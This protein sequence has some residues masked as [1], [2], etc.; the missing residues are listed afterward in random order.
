MS[1]QSNA[2]GPSTDIEALRK[3]INLPR[4]PVSV[5]W[6]AAARG[7]AAGSEVPGPT[8]TYIMAVLTFTPEDMEELIAEAARHERPRFSA[9]VEDVG[10]LPPDVR[11][12]ASKEPGED[13]FTLQGQM[14]DPAAFVKPPLMGGYI[15]RVGSTP[16]LFI[17]L[18]TT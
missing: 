15:L 4:R 13:S 11:K 16:H 18:Y 9:T 5:V 17:Y 6:R 3:Y 10:W 7:G 14:Y 1:T 8:D 2:P 12:Y